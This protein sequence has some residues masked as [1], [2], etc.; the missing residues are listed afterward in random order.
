MGLTIAAGTLAY[1]EHPS[2]VEAAAD[3]C[4]ALDYW[5][6]F[7]ADV[8]IAD[9]AGEAWT[10]Q[11]GLDNARRL[12]ADWYL[13]IDAD[14]RLIDGGRLYEYLSQHAGGL[15]WWPLPYL[16][17]Q[18]WTTV[19]PCKL[20]R[21]ADAECFLA[22]DVYTIG[23]RV[24]LLSGFSWPAELDP[25]LPSLPRLLHIPSA[26]P[27]APGRRR[28][29]VAIEGSDQTGRLGAWKPE[30]P[31][32]VPAA[33]RSGNGNLPRGGDVSESAD[34]QTEHTAD[35]GAYYCP[36]CGQRYDTAGVCTG[37]EGGAGHEAIAVEKVS[38]SKGKSKSKDDADDAGKTDDAGK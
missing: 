28:L 21:V 16:Q 30:L 2:M 22:S 5:F 3:S 20:I 34:V 38:G 35:E 33:V 31:F 32:T 26:R 12:G 25:I 6:S 9:E 11:R 1:N 10:R 17:E 19:A 23:G 18:G 15:G 14:E 13:Q 36:G 37:P 8:E 29:S 4:D 24:T 7:G 27:D